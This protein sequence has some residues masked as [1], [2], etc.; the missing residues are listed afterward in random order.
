M[1]RFLAHLAVIERSPD[2]VRAY[3]SSL[4]LW[5]ERLELRD[6]VW[7]G[8][9]VEDVSQ[10]VRWLRAPADGVMMLDASAARR[11]EATVNRHLAAVFAFYDFH[12]RGG[13]GAGRGPGGV[14]AG[15]VIRGA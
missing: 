3:A 10:L 5:W 7:K 1:E 4:A 12:A 13:S 6:S 8:V 2:T 9:K 15:A 11:I 14:A